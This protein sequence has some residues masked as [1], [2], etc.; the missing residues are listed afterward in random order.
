MTYDVSYRSPNDRKWTTVANVN[1]DAI[2]D[3][4][5]CQQFPVRVLILEDETRI[6]IPMSWAIRYGRGRFELIRDRMSQEAGQEVRL[7]R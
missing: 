2:M 7:K 5:K 3:D 4:G 6:E 1:G